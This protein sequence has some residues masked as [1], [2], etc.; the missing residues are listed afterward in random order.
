MKKNYHSLG[1]V[2]K[3][4]VNEP[5]N[6]VCKFE[7]R[8]AKYKFSA[9]NYGEIPKWHN[10][11][12]GD[13]WDVF[14]PGYKQHLYTDKPYVIDKV[15]GVFVLQNG[16]HKIAVRLK[17]IPI[18]SLKYERHIIQNYTKKYSQCTK[19]KGKYFTL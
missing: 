4:L 19:I 2:M 8:P 13:P 10:H 18:T 16:N 3:K 17:D 7:N 14:A 9:N 15:I 12:D 5:C 6:H 11:A 1:Y